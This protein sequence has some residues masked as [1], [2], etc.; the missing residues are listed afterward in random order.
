MAIVDQFGRPVF[1]ARKFAHAA[2]PNRNRGPQFYDRDQDIK[3]LI[4]AHDR[5]SLVGLSK[6]LF[7]N[8]GAP[9]RAA[10]R[11]KADYTV[12]SAWLPIYGGRD[13]EAGEEAASWLREVFYPLADVRG[14]L[15][16]W[17]CFLKLSSIELDKGGDVFVLLTSSKEGFP[18]I[19]FIPSYLVWS[20]AGEDRV[21]EGPYRGL[22]LH[23]GIIYNGQN[24]P[25]A[26]RVHLSENQTR[27]ISA[28]DLIHLY[29]PSFQDQGRGLPAFT[30]ALD[31]LKAMLQSKEYE[32]IRQQVLSSILFVEENDLGG[33]D[34]SDP[35]FALSTDSADATGIAQEQY[36]PAVHYFRA[37]SG[38]GLKTVTH[39]T[40]GEVW[41]SFHDRLIRSAL[42]GM[43][44]SYSLVWKAAGQGTAERTEIERA[45]RSVGERQMLLSYL[46]KRV[47]T[48]ALAVA[49]QPF[50]RDKKKIRDPLILLPE[51]MLSWSFSL[52]PR[53][54][55]D[56]GREAKS[57][58]ESARAG[59]T[60]DT[61]ILAWKGRTPEDHYRE[62]AEEIV[63]RKRV[64]KEISE[65]EGIPILDQE[66]I[67]FSPNDLPGPSEPPSLSFD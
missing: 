51:N 64:A 1:I 54:T 42:A 23:D 13:K 43:G 17:H 14:G 3:Q 24:A 46:A 18:R 57:Q 29:D 58:L 44:W 10:I 8:M 9:M 66:M 61:E 50:F 22:K 37:N 28:R 19:Q 55:L 26:Y 67:M 31:D 52:P 11:Q 60:N 34:M 41:E 32:L 40:P 21:R 39:D 65:R 56:D 53:L 25:V 4:P 62:R 7:V 38:G 20:E 59:K 63:L 2:D 45:R 33:P 49:S 47:V 48:Y 12:G 35:R 36:G 15:H 16:S 30:H 27:D 6:R 5:R